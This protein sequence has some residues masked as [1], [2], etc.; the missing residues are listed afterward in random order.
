MNNYVWLGASHDASTSK[1]LWRI[2][3]QFNLLRQSDAQMCL[4]INGAQLMAC[5]LVGT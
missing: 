3:I 2:F 5:R 1:N 4:A